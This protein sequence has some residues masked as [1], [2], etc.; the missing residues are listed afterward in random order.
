MKPRSCK[1][2]SL[3]EYAVLFAIVVAAFMGMQI[4]IKRGV[5]GGISFCSDQIGN[6]EDFINLSDPI[7]GG[8]DSALD[9]D[10]STGTTTITTSA[11]GTEDHSIS[12]S[13]SKG[14]QSYSAYNIT[15][16]E[17]EFYGGE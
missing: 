12:Q 14:A 9:V 3:G 2:Q 16:V 1:G 4:F 17:G 6:Q 8:L 13:A 5:Q 7:K 15:W 10:R 11:G